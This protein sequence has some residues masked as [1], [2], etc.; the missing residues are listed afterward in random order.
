MPNN[1]IIFIEFKDSKKWRCKQ[2]EL[3]LNLQ[4]LCFCG[5]NP[6][7]ATFVGIHN[8]LPQWETI[9]FLPEEIN[10]PGGSVFKRL[11]QRRRPRFD[12]WVGKIPEK[13]MATHSRRASSGNRKESDTTEQQKF[14]FQ[15]ENMTLPTCEG[16]WHSWTLFV[17]NGSEP[18]A[19]S[20]L[21]TS[22]AQKFTYGMVRIT[23]KCDIFVYMW[24]SSV[25]G[26][27]QAR[28]PEWVAIPFFRGSSQPRDQ[29][30]VSCIAG[31]LFPF[32]ATKEAP[33]HL[34]PSMK[35][36]RKWN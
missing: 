25:H 32:W 26:I 10:F 18:G 2:K 22:S 34:T 1:C 30:Q 15:G 16:L 23:D 24:G 31:G 5:F 29:S 21:L 33:F 11:P 28:I 8:G 13:E 19:P 12:P 20:L 7:L 3:I 6:Y 4:W 9:W 36:L 17:V 35:W 27:F 14:H